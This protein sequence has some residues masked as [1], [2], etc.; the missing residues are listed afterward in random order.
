M[1]WDPV[2]PVSLGEEQMKALRELGYGT[3]GRLPR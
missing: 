3:G 2:D 1:F